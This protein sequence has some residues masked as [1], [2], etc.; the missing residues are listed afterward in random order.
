MNDI[1]LSYDHEDRAHAERVVQALEAYGWSVSWDRDIEVGEEWAPR[2][3]RELAEASCVLVLWTER[4]RASTWVNKEARYGASKR[5]LAQA[6]LDEG[7]APFE[8]EH[9]Q[10]ADLSDWT[11]GAGKEF[12]KLVRRIRQL[13]GGTKTVGQ[14]RWTALFR[15]DG[16]VRAL[17]FLVVTAVTLGVGV[18]STRLFTQPWTVLSLTLPLLVALRLAWRKW[19]RV[20]DGRD[21]LLQPFFAVLLAIYL[22]LFSA[23]AGTD[24]LTWRRSLAGFDQTREGWVSPFRDPWVK[25]YWHLTTAYR[26]LSRLSSPPYAKAFTK[27][28]YVT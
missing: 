18:G 1:F 13:C 9:E 2:I 21:L 16:L 17:L 3:E 26:S 28:P 11:G 5:K 12:E 4:S 14:I 19:S 15:N 7:P 24:L 6:L 27:C 23:A 20:R 25:G 10:A 8:F 22:A